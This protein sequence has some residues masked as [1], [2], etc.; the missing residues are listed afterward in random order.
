MATL[1]TRFDYPMAAFHTGDNFTMVTSTNSRLLPTRL[2]AANV[3]EV[4]QSVTKFL[5]GNLRNT[6][7]VLHQRTARRG[8]LH[9]ELNDRGIHEQTARTHTQESSL[10]AV[11]DLVARASAH[12]WGVRFC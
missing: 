11:P 3:G 10:A 6:R 8:V 2:F 5:S 7:P 12:G 9:R 4:Y 1:R